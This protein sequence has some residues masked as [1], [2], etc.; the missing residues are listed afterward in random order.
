MNPTRQPAQFPSLSLRMLAACIL[1]AAANLSAQTLGTMNMGGNPDFS[2]DSVASG[3][4]PER[5][6]HSFPGSR[7]SLNPSAPKTFA[8][9]PTPPDLALDLGG[10]LGEKVLR[11]PKVARMILLD[12][13]GKELT[14]AGQRTDWFPYKLALRAQFDAGLALSA[15]DFFVDADSSLLRVI[16]VRNAGKQQLQLFAEAPENAGIE[17]QEEKKAIHVTGPD[18]HYSL[19]FAEL[20]GAEGQPTPTGLNPEC[21]ASGW[22]I[23]LPLADGTNRFA[24]GFGFATRGEGAGKAIER[25]LQ[26]ISRPVP[27]TLAN[28]R[29]AIEEALRKV[30][31]PT[32]WGLDPK[33]A[34]GITPEQQRQA[35]YMAWTFL[36][37]STIKILPEKPDFPYPQM[38][39]GKAALWADGEHRAPATCAWESLI[40][41]QWLSF[42]DTETAW[43]DSDRRS[44]VDITREPLVARHRVSRV[45]Q[46]RP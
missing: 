23:T 30:P 11:L 7:F 15:D 10:Y 20:N 24:M 14:P 29:A 32:V 5:R 41:M 26:T 16:E 22:K 34:A 35:Y 40:G 21:T 17:W 46:S 39:L 44:A 8:M 3:S 28:S 25:A 13:G 12:S 36:L 18:Y 6:W 45:V 4:G 2:A 37:Q 1:T 42:V 9:D 43:K 33:L 38:S 19:C 27:M 31:A